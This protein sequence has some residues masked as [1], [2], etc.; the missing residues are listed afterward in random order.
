M[1]F[2]WKVW[3]AKGMAAILNSNTETKDLDEAIDFTIDCVKNICSEHQISL[4]DE[5]MRAYAALVI[6]NNFEDCATRLY[7]K[8]ITKLFNFGDD[9]DTEE[10]ETEE[11]ETEE[12]E[13]DDTNATYSV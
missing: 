10:T 3:R 11:T 4:T 1:I 6:S 8:V 9:T 7:P 5:Q 13:A 2:I 12:I